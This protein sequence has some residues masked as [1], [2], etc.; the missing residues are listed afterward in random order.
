V[1]DAHEFSQIH[2]RCD[3]ASLSTVWVRRAMY[4]MHPGRSSTLPTNLPLVSD[5]G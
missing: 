2:L 1:S 3:R 5:E 4:N